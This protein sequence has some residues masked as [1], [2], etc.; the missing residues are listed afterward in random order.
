MENHAVARLLYGR[1]ALESASTAGECAFEHIQS[2]VTKTE[3]A[4]HYMG[5]GVALRGIR[6]VELPHGS[7]HQ[8][9]HYYDSETETER[10]GFDLFFNLPQYIMMS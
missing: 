10:V 7:A 8:T 9:L 4:M 3:H 6:R 5:P 1:G 2:R